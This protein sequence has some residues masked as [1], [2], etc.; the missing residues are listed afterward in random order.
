MGTTKW[1]QISQ[2]MPL[3]DGK[4][5][6][7]RWHNHLNPANKRCPWNEREEWLLYLC[8]KYLGN[9][10]SAIARIISGRSDNT[11]KNHWNCYIKRH[12]STFDAKFKAFLDKHQINPE[13]K[14]TPNNDIY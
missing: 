12:M 4:Q 14:N 3:R 5:C 13:E 8:H 7:E 11:I 1:V 10:W 6:R 9:K 2:K